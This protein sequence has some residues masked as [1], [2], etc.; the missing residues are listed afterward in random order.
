MIRTTALALLLL[1]PAFA[2]AAPV[3]V[4][5]LTGVQGIRENELFGYGLVVG[6]SGTGDTERVFFTSQSI[7]GMLGRLGVRIDP[8]EVRVRNVAAVMVTARL[9]PFVR[10]GTKIDVNVASMGNARSLAGGVLLVTPLTAAD[11]EVYAV[12]QGAV[13]VGGFDA[14]SSGSR[15]QKNSPTSGRIPA[16]AIVE[17]SAILDLA[18]GPLVLTLDDPDFATANSIAAAIRSDL[19]LQAKAVDPAAVEVTLTDEDRPLLVEIVSKIQALEVEADRRAKVVVSERTGTVVSGERVRIRP[20]SVSH[21]GI[22]I[23]IGEEPVVSQPTP[24]SEGRTVRDRVARIEATEVNRGAVALPATTSVDEL[25]RALNSLGV[26][27]RDLIAILQA[28]KAAGALDADL[29][30]I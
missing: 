20:V 1:V 17:R 21:G 27:P 26:T 29:E 24:F 2:D 7:A 12:S 10:P 14:A 4:K 19:N 18:E 11:G 25:V 13:Q 28:I 9:P 23:A 16:G 6:L 8:R 15:L 5:E 30:V 22:Q 3:R